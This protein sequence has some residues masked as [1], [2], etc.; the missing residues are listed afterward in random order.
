[1]TPEACKWARCV[2]CPS[3]GPGQCALPGSNS[4]QYNSFGRYP[5]QSCLVG[6]SKAPAPAGT[7][8]AHESG[9][10]M[11]IL[12]DAY[13]VIHKRQGSH[14]LHEGRGPKNNRFK[15]KCAG[16]AAISCNEQ[17]QQASLQKRRCSRKAAA[18]CWRRCSRQACRSAGSAESSCSP[19]VQ[20]QQGCQKRKC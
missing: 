11:C 9:L 3:G 15:M 2:M 13:I 17:V 14:Q 5:T 20:V 1:M 16:A 12:T 8:C 6:C 7:K 10:C 18:A 19:L 4:A